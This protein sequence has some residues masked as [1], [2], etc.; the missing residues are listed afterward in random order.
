MSCWDILQ[1]EAGA[2]KKAIKKA[3]AKLLKQTRP[4]DDPDAFTRLHNAYK[5]ALRLCDADSGE[6]VA[7]RQQPPQRATVVTEPPPDNSEDENALQEEQKI[8]PLRDSADPAG[9]TEPSPETPPDTVHVL[10]APSEI[11]D[12]AEETVRHDEQVD[13]THELEAE[14]NRDNVL[15]ANRVQ[16]LLSSKRRSNRVS[17][18]QFIETVPSMVDL[19][20]RASISERVF[21]AV[22][23]SNVVALE[24]GRLQVGANVLRYL[25]RYFQWDSN[26]QGFEARY[27]EDAVKAV[28]DYQNSPTIRVNSEPRSLYYFARIAAFAVDA[29]IAGIF[30]IVGTSEPYLAFLH[31]IGTAYVL[32]LMPLLE[33]SPWQ[34]SIGKRIF[35]LTVVN[36][37]GLRLSWYHSFFR[38]YVSYF[39][40]AAIKITVWINAFTSYRY[41]ALLQDLISQS[42]IVLRK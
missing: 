41:H 13:Q 15:I 8:K 38:S 12:H 3:Y 20:F 34:G 11:L 5:T 26:W 33:A 42:Y 4:D 23:A 22:S 27:G 37:N 21:D 16:E 25:T 30:I 24:K 19:Q 9:I 1:I 31:Y 6:S 17:E 14:F 10:S 35:D 18:W 40:L 36:N 32:L 7:S 28:F 39:C 29:L 2:D